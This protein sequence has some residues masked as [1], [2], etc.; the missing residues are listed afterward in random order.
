MN[1]KKIGLREIFI[2]LFIAG[3]SVS[4]V[5]FFGRQS[6]IWRTVRIMVGEEAK[7][8]DFWLSE[9]IEI[10][11]VEF[12]V[13]GSKIAEIIKI[14]SYE[15]DKEKVNMYLTVKVKTELNKKLNKYVYKGRAIEAG[16]LIEFRLPQALVKGVIIDDQVLEDGYEQKQVIVKGRWQAQKNQLV[17]KIKVGDKMFDLGGQKAVAEV[18]KV[19]VISS[20]KRTTIG[21]TANN[22]LEI[23]ANPSLVDGIITLKLLVEKHDNRWFF[24]GDQKIKI[25]QELNLYL[26]MVDAVLEIE[27]VDWLE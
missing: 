16:S 25:G 15:A 11:E 17:D 22:Q 3:L 18:L 24:A 27:D 7:K 26:P 1:I 5:K 20:N 9:N 12:G 4:L 14:E 6:G 19:W 8:P 2:L 13:D 21:F 23:A 10:G